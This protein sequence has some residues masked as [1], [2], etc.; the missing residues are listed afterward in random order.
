MLSARQDNP[1]KRHGKTRRWMRDEQGSVIV[2]IAMI[3]PVLLTLMLGTLELGLT[4]FAQSLMDGAARDAARVIRTGGVQ[5]PPGDGAASAAAAQA[6]F[7]KIL[8]QET[9]DS[10]GVGVVSTAVLDCEKYIYVVQNY[11]TVA[12][13]NN[14]INPAPPAPPPVPPAAT[15]FS[16]GNPQDYV[17]VQVFYQRPS[18]LPTKVTHLLANAS[19]QSTVIFR[20][21]PFPQ[22]APGP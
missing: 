6:A 7:K 18:L 3:L 13:L 8:C 20:N 17:S 21:E 22:A 15:S 4:L 9:G 1:M 16:P 11:A 14:A 19:L 12:A 5:V 10:S 2:E